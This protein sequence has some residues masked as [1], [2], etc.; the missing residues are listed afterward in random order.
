VNCDLHSSNVL[1]TSDWDVYII[2]FA[3][4][5]F[6]DKADNPGFFFR[7]LKDLD[8]HAFERMKC[9]YLC[10]DAP[11]PEGFFGVCYDLCSLKRRFKK[12]NRPKRRRR[13]K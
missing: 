5:C 10:L 3:S 6:T 13:S 9:K 11:V 12:R 2:D 8:L 7:G 1:L 4:A